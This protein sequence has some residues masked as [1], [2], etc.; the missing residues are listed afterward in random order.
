MVAQTER[1][2]LDQLRLEH[3][4]LIATDALEQM[5]ADDRENAF[6]A[7]LLEWLRNSS[8]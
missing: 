8:V 5:V 7:L 1:H 4:V 3:A 6:A 2:D